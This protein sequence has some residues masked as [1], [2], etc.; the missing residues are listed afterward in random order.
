VQWYR[1]AAEHGDDTAQLH[2]GEA[3]QEGV[4]VAQDMG[5]ALVW[6]RKAADQGND[7]AQTYLGQ[8]YQLGSGAPQDYAQAAD[9]YRKSAVQGNVTAQLNLGFIYHSGGEGVARDATQAIE[10]WRKAADQGN[11]S[12]QFNLSVSYHNG[13]GV[14]KDGVEA[15]KWAEIA[16]ANAPEESRRKYVAMRASLAND[17]PAEGIAEAQKRAREWSDDLQRRKAEDLERHKR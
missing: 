7:R 8:A 14:P 3:Y 10:W 16:V 2:L 4:G 5:Q 9:W 1:K 6:W 11:A 15:Y 13:E 17:L 12:A